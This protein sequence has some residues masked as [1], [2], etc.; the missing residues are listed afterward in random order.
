MEKYNNDWWIGR[1]VR[2]E[3]EVGFIPSPLKIAQMRQQL[4]EKKKG[5]RQSYNSTMKSNNGSINHL[6][7]HHDYT[8][9]RQN[10]YDYDFDV[11]VIL[12]F[13]VLN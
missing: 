4:R 8:Q 7:D 9:E 11:K 5:H 13:N 3:G 10:D 2:R 12:F 1:V 6:D